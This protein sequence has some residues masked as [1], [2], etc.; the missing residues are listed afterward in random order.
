[1]RICTLHNCI[2]K[3]Y[4]KG[5]CKAHFERNRKTG[6]PLGKRHLCKVESCKIVTFNDKYCP[7]HAKRL[8]RGLP[9]I[10]LGN[11]GK[12]NPR[13]KGGVSD[14][15]NHYLMKKQRVIKVKQVQAKCKI[16]NKDGKQ[17]HHK[18]GSRS[19]HK[20]SNLIF[21]CFKCHGLLHRI[22]N[23]GGRTKELLEL[24]D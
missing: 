2:K 22:L 19:N 15:D 18:D 6:N 16:C 10:S 9:L 23:R 1:M 3:H 11:K 17:I 20:L 5:M 14:Y 24:L 12:N 4:A 7:L 8:K 13:W 21:V